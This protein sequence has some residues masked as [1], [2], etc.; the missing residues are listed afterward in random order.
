MGNLGASIVDCR[1]L[2]LRR[3][4]QQ[5]KRCGVTS[6]LTLIDS[7]SLKDYFKGK[8]VMAVESASLPLKTAG[9]LAASAAAYGDE[10]TLGH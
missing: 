6:G 4:F 7:I 1:R 9:V 5:I 2:H 10:A 3:H 8:L